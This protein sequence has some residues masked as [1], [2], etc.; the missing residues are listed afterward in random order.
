MKRQQEEN[1]RREEEERRERV[2]KSSALLQ[3]MK[4]TSEKKE[5]E[6]RGI[7]NNRAAGV[8]THRV[9]CVLLCDL[10]F[11][12]E[13]ERAI[14]RSSSA[15]CD[16]QQRGNLNTT[17]PS[18]GRPHPLATTSS[19]KHTGG[20]SS[21]SSVDPSL[22]VK[23]KTKS[24]SSKTS[25]HYSTTKNKKS[26]SPVPNNKSLTTTKQP[27]SAAS[28]KKPSTP[29][30]VSKT[31]NP[32]S[33][34]AAAASPAR[35]MQSSKPRVS[36]KPGGGVSTSRGSSGVPKAPV[37]FQELLK[38]AKEKKSLQNSDSGRS[39]DQVAVGGSGGG[40]EAG[41]ER[42]KSP[43]GRG[44]SS[45]PLGKQLLERGSGRGRQRERVG[46]GGGGGGERK[47]SGVIQQNGSKREDK[48]GSVSDCSAVG[49][50]LRELAQSRVV[51]RGRGGARGAARGKLGCA[52]TTTTQ[53]L[54]ESAILMRER[55]RRE[56]EGSA[57]GRKTGS[58]T[59]PAANSAKSNSFY[60]SSHAQLS[61]EGR[62]EFS[63]RKVLGGGVQDSLWVGE[64]SEYVER[65]REGGE[66]GY[67]EE[68]DEDLEDFVVDDE[69]GDDVSS[70]IREIFGYDRRR[71]ASK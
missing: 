23:Q 26:S 41:P 17:T 48:D 15:G 31:K 61:Q 56:L 34:S 40:K 53:G 62:P 36:P 47:S 9:F 13:Y 63:K 16:G 12:E 38:L 42:G 67:S 71:Y 8:Y 18:N 69:E 37:N 24:S 33:S 3:D 19:G 1:R 57:N 58:T 29:G 64:M 46:G 66:E 5:R 20:V 54:P 27:N 6:Y 2:R 52:G 44:R 7:V 43:L 65:L 14:A 49:S 10:F 35:A 21:K 68:E 22:S 51:G 4:K 55:F 60:A 32:S 70:A 39:R 50:N 30:S 45:S 59:K 28:L 25:G 11:F